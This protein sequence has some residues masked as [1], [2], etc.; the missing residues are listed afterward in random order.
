M[1]KKKELI[2]KHKKPNALSMPFPIGILIKSITIEI[3]AHIIGLTQ[4][5]NG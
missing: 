1:S 3:N 2:E 5:E 4:L